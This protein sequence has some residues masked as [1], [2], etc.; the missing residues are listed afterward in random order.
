MVMTIV[1]GGPGSGGKLKEITPAGMHKHPFVP[2]W[3]STGRWHKISSIP[4]SKTHK[5]A[6]M[7]LNEQNRKIKEKLLQDKKKKLYEKKE[8]LKLDNLSVYTPTGVLDTGEINREKIKERLE[9]IEDELKRKK[10][11]PVKRA[12]KLA[13]IEEKLQ[14]EVF[15]KYPKL[16]WEELHV[17]KKIHQDN[18]TEYNKDN[19]RILVEPR[20]DSGFNLSYTNIKTG[21]NKIFRVNTFVTAQQIAEKVFQEQEKLLDSAKNKI[22]KD[23]LEIADTFTPTYG[24]YSK[25]MAKRKNFIINSI[26]EIL[27]KTEDEISFKKPITD[28]QQKILGKIDHYLVLQ[29]DMHDIED[30][31]EDIKRDQIV[32]NI[33][34]K[35]NTNNLLKKSTDIDTI[36]FL[37]GYRDLAYQGLSYS[38]NELETLFKQAK[39]IYS[40]APQEYDTRLD[41]IIYIDSVAHALHKEKDSAG[42]SKFVILDELACNAKEKGET[43]RDERIIVLAGDTNTKNNL[44]KLNSVFEI[45][46]KQQTRKEILQLKSEFKNNGPEILSNKELCQLYRYYSER[47]FELENT[48]KKDLRTLENEIEKRNL[49]SEDILK[50]SLWDSFIIG[51]YGS[52]EIRDSE[53]HKIRLEGLKKAIP[54]FMFDPKFRNVMI[55]HCLAPET[56]IRTTKGFRQIQ[57]IRIGDRVYS[58]TGKSRKVLKTIMH[59]NNGSILNIELENNE[60]IQVTSEHPILTKRGWIKAGELK[61]E[62]ILLTLDTNKKFHAQTK[63]KTLQEIY[64]NKYE[65]HINKL[66][67]PHKQY[68]L[69]SKHNSQQRKGKTWHS[70]YGHNKP[71]YGGCAGEKNTM[72]GKIGRITGERNPNWEGGKS[73]LPYTKE[74]NSRIKEIIKMKSNYTCEKCGMYYLECKEKYKKD[75]NIHHKDFDKSNCDLNNLQALCV[76]CHNTISNLHYAESR[77]NNKFVLHNGTKIVSITTTWYTG[78]VYNLEISIDHTYVGKGIIYHN[79]DVQIANLL[80]KFV[81]HENEVFSTHIDNIGFYGIIE[82]REDIEIAKK[83]QTEIENGNLRSFSIAGTAKKKEDVGAGQFDIWDLEAYELT[84]CCLPKQQI[85]TKYGTKNIEDIKVNDEVLTHKNRY[86]KVTKTFKRKINERIV[87]IKTD[88]NKILQVTTE[89]LIL[90]KNRGWIKAKELTIGDEI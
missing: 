19:I 87:L 41:K 36:K 11:P 46:Q 16:W 67:K 72:F 12:D 18:T 44:E 37:L 64:D 13:K 89:H 8:K 70:V 30:E 45:I 20:L 81:N 1:K 52:V 79:S 28:L 85:Q 63:N 33:P 62:D 35:H 80:P 86:R 61:L 3:Y 53:G 29:Q 49:N 55:F 25:T 60:I 83:V 23:I 51:G 27:D 88:T 32:F 56:L 50:F 82:L 48:S 90:T 42:K 31:I 26:S 58:H 7:R 78:K 47:Y 9:L 22:R 39:E 84:I 73:F 40:I 34:D 77:K 15:G 74:F 6:H 59:E 71:N 65:E 57:D 10:V 76:K 66:R 54:N 75:L 43:Q 4:K 5:L 68:T 2:V 14:E 38:N 21:L 24:G 69:T 17:S